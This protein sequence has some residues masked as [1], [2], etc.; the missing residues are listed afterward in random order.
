MLR[1]WN[2]IRNRAHEFPRRW[3]HETSERAEAQSFW[4]EFFAV[5]GIDRKRV[6]V[7]EKQVEVT[8]AG[9][10]IAFTLTDRHKRIKHFAF[11]AGYK[12]QEIAPQ[13]PVNIKAAELH[14][15]LKA[16]GYQGHA[17]ELLLVRLRPRL[18]R[19][20]PGQIDGPLVM[21][22]LSINEMSG[23]HGKG[24]RNSA[25]SV[26]LPLNCNQRKCGACPQNSTGKSDTAMD[27]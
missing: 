5:F 22:C 20:F 10:N 24:L 8:R 27:N 7:F 12:T 1:S 9:N 2:G 19:H 17:L 18:E 4:T 13:N 3:A 26:A 15:L 21:N 6:A 16:A 23:S 11:I 25:D 14:D